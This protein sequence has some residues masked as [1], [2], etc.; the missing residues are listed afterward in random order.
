MM[1][2]PREAKGR[3]REK[4][5]HSNKGEKKKKEKSFRVRRIRRAEKHHGGREKN[6]LVG[7]DLKEKSDTE[8]ES[9]GKAMKGGGLP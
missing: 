3:G 4:E 5:A 1:A 6:K 2:M 8:N 7:V 9:S